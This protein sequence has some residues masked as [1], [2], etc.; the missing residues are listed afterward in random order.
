[1]YA[2]ALNATGNTADAY[3]YVDRVRERANLLPLSEAKPGLSQDAFLE[4]IKHERLLELS[5]E[6]HRWNDLARWGDL[7]PELADRDPGFNNF[8]IGKHELLPIPQQD[9]DI[10]PALEQ[11]PN[12]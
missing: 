2:E 11:N 12:W 6:G 8:D 7:G 5:G 1:M 4:Q 10:N 3:Q 9:I